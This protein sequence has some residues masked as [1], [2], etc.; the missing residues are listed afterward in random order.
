MSTGFRN[1]LKNIF[2]ILK[3]VLKNHFGFL[4]WI[5]KFESKNRFKILNLKIIL[6]FKV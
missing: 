2:W 3:V 6:D 1:F 4:F 5:L